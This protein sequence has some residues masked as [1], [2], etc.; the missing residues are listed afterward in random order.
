ML[1]ISIRIVEIENTLYWPV[2]VNHLNHRNYHLDY[3]PIHI[4]SLSAMY[5]KQINFPF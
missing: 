2:V 1:M 5:K 3:S 4:E